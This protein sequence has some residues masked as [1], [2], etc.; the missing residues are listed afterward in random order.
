MK[1]WIIRIITLVLLGGLISSLVYVYNK[2]YFNDFIKAINGSDNKG[3]TLYYRDNKNEYRGKKSYCIE[4]KD[5]NDSLFFKEIEVEKETPYRI[6][7]MIK[8]E[9]VE[10]DKP[11][12]SGACI[13]IMGTADQT[14]PIQGT[15][16]W[17]K[18]SL[19][20][21]S[22]NQEKLDI[23]FRLGGNDGFA[24]GKAWFS[25]IHVEKGVKDASNNWNVVCFLINNIDVTIEGKHYTY[26]LTEEDKELLETNLQRYANTCEI[27]SNGL[28]TVSYKIIEINEPLTSLSYDEENY[29]Y[30]AP[31]DVKPLIDKYVK[32]NE[33]DHIFVGIRMGDKNG[34][35]PVNEWI[36]LGSM[37]YDSIGFS[38]IKMPD[39]LENSTMYKYNIKNDTF[40]EEVFV[41]EFLHSLERNLVE[42]G[43][44]FPALHDNEKLGYKSQAVS[45]LKEWYKD[46]MMCN[47]DSNNG[48]TGLDPI[49]YKT[50]PIHESNFAHS[51]EIEFE[52]VPHNIIDIGAQLIENFMRVF[53][54]ER[55]NQITQSNYVTKTTD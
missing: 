43:Y 15:T 44:T 12:T 17:Q 23:S 55:D 31:K 10:S 18:I 24:K 21:D 49:V 50:K 47:I 52:K 34:K 2:Y 39:D 4:N 20:V 33:F 30:V 19:L 16:D 25:D 11:E 5:F 46:Y 29:Y 48:K 7:C 54:S 53:S 32:E 3:E 26:S 8:T 9:N 40:P 13:S 27:F 1:K 45:G 35:I 14:I 6:T 41:H 38:D 51:T 42:K 37:R 36:G 22:K 28:M